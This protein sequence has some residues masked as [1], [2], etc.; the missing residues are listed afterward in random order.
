MPLLENIAHLLDVV[1]GRW[2][3]WRSRCQYDSLPDELRLKRV[4]VS[5]RTFQAVM[6]HP[7]VTQLASEA[8]AILDPDDPLMHINIL[9]M[10]RPDVFR[11]RMVS[12]TIRWAHNTSPEQSAE[13]LGSAMKFI[14]KQIE[15]IPLTRLSVEQRVGVM[16]ARRAARLSTMGIDWRMVS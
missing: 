12:L 16:E 4:E 1:A 8:A 13:R 2:F 6:E 5:D 7:A 14:L 9:M 10:P 3:D 15:Q 11:G